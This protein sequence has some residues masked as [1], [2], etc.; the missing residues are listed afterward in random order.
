[1]TDKQP[2]QHPDKK[3][4]YGL[5]SAGI[6]CDGWLFVSG[7]GPLDMQTGT[8]VDGTI[9][10]QTRLTIG[11]IEAILAEAGAGLHDIVRCTCYLA[12]LADFEGFNRVYGEMLPEPRPARATVGAALMKNM[13][14]E[15]EAIARMPQG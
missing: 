6:V 11:H 5:F 12:D 4:S 8:L 14:V 3:F 15:I 1:M 7:Q 2:V 9:E 13:K 10:E